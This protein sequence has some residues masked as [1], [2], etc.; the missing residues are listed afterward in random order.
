MGPMG[1][2]QHEGNAVTEIKNDLTLE[3]AQQY[4]AEVVIDLGKTKANRTHVNS[5]R[6]MLKLLAQAERELTG[7][8]GKEKK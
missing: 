1:Q 4:I 5:G 3:Q 8:Y 2:A 7:N 6:G